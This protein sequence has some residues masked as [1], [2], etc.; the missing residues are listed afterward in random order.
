MTRYSCYFINS[1][2]KAEKAFLIE[3]PTAA[4][5]ADE[6]LQRHVSALYVALE[7]WDG[8]SRVHH[9]KLRPARAATSASPRR[10][11]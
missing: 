8:A 6:A 9:R 7:V 2:D 11:A 5:A 10:G 4:A 1:N 3:A